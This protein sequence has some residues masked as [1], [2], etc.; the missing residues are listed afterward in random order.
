[1]YE[2]EP[3]AMLT[4]MPRKTADDRHRDSAPT[5]TP[6]S[7]SGSELVD[8]LI[9]FHH[10]TRRWLLEVLGVDGPATVGMLA[11]KT[12]LAAGSISHHLNSLHRY[13]FI[14]PAPELARDTRESWWRA[15]PRRLT[16]SADDFAPGT[17]D[18]RIADS[19]EAENFK[20]QVRAIRQWVADE[21]DGDPWREQA[22]STDTMCRATEAQLADLGQRLDDL[23]TTWADECSADRDED[24]DAERRMIRVISRAFPSSAV[25]P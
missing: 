23:L 3:A 24:P 5:S 17:A 7:E 12:G 2:V 18:R 9:A 20:H 13:G 6:G 8:V 11:G 1:L 10:P 22:S 25:R 16:W 19:A 21:R 4:H 15:V 14:E